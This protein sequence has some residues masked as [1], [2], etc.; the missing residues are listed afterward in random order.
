MLKLLNVSK[1]FGN[2]L[3]IDNISLTVKEG[4]I[5]GFIGPNGAGKST[6]IRMILDMLDKD[7]GEILIFN[8][9]FST[10]LLRKIGYL[11]G[12]IFLYDNLKALDLLKYSES[13]YKQ[14]FSKERER[15]AKLLDFDLS[16]KIG[17]LS[18]GNKK[19]L[20]IID[21][22]Q[23]N[24]ELIILDEPTNGLDPLIQKKLFEL[25]LEKKAQGKTI[26][27][28]SHVLSDVQKICDKVS[29]IKNGKILQEIDLKNERLN[30][31]EVIVKTVGDLEFTGITNKWVDGEVTKLHYKGDYQFLLS[32]L[33]EYP[34]TDIQINDP[35]LE[36][37]FMHYYE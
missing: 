9:V 19:K 8:Q 35:S 37:L 30:F 36:E 15:L 23:H 26:F 20:G 29:I 34:I 31:K 28:S 4:E 27:F 1:S 10:E 21:A 13:F 32:K 22:L 5:Y 7:Q 14:D 24:P 6:T 3:V 2:K 33:S 17:K 18:L 16:M 11:P 12:E 25:I